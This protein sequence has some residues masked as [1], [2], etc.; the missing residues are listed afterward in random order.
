MIYYWTL[1]S[2]PPPLY[3]LPHSVLR[4]KFADIIA[5][6]EN[7][8]EQHKDEQ[9][10]V[11]SIVGCLQELLA[12]QDAPNWSMPVTKKAFQ[13]LLILS[14]NASPKV[15]RLILANG[16]YVDSETDEIGQCRPVR[17]LKMP[18]AMSCRDLLLLLPFTLLLTWHLNSSSECCMRLPNLINTLLN[19]CSLCSRLLC[20]TGHLM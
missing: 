10:I 13:Q 15:T 16:I 9:P 2:S 11:R 7:V 20:P 14:A 5:I 8:F 17:E 12:A 1:D 4:S 19:K 3:S 18:F 6:I